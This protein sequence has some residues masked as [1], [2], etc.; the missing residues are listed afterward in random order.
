[1]E[2]A[3]KGKNINLTMDFGNREIFIYGDRDKF[4]QMMI[5]LV[6]NAIKYTNE[7]GIVSINSS[8]SNGRLTIII[9]DNG[10][11]IPQNNL[12]RLFERFYRVDRGRSR[13]RGGTGLGLAIVKHIVNLLN[14][15][16]RVE[17]TVGKG[18]SF[19]IDFPS[20]EFYNKPQN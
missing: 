5:N 15:N 6:D 9:K 19:I 16:I 2:P 12:P 11:G 10:I 3:A 20:G 8:L 18:S 7:G 17:S 4:K 1:M 14:G 13:E